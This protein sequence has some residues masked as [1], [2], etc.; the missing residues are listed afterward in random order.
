MALDEA[1]TYKYKVCIVQASYNHNVICPCDGS[2][3][4]IL[5]LYF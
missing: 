4:K 2:E 3:Y 5:I 1:R